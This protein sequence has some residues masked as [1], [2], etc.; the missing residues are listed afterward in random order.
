MVK[1]LALGSLVGGLLAA[2]LTA[3]HYAASFLIGTSFIPFD[4]FNWMVRVLPGDL[5]TF[6]IDMMIDTMLALG[7]SVV[8][9]AKTAERVSAVLQFVTMLLLVGALLFAI[10][11]LRK[12]RRPRL[13]GLIAGAVIG[14]PLLTISQSIAQLGI[15]SL[16]NGLWLLLSF[17]LWGWLM[18]LAYG[19]LFSTEPKA[20]IVVEA[21]P[22]NVQVINRRK[23]LVQLGAS[24]AV[25]TVAGTGIGAALS[26]AERARLA[27]GGA[28]ILSGDG[29]AIRFPNANDPVMPVPGTRPEYTPIADHYQVFLQ[30]EPTIIEEAEWVLPIGGMVSNP[31]MFTLQ[32]FRDEFESFDQ[33]VTLTCISGRVGTGLIG[34][35]KWTGV[36]AQDVL[37][38]VGVQPEAKYLFITSG[39]GFYET[40]DLELIRNDRRIMFCYAWDDKLLPKDH[41]FPLR[42]WIPDLYGMKQ[43]KWITGIE[44]TD[45]DQPGYWVERNWDKVARVKAASTIHTVAV[46]NIGAANGQQVIPIGGAAYAGAR[47]IGS[48]EIRVDGGDW[49]S[50]QLR[51]PLSETTWVIWRYEW[52][53]TEGEHLFEVRCTEADGT[54]QIEEA[55]TARPDGSSGIHSFEAAV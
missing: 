13:A 5:I 15:S 30:T 8:D 28:S 38:A 51:A 10:W 35:T 55:Q 25:I 46:D 49:Q 6:G 19:R 48:V 11:H 50:A 16:L 2:A 39:D 52:P 29:A 33:Y 23:F 34:T 7:L 54:P 3:V 32:Q 36:S 9:L 37:E 40:I 41:G 43:P 27:A 21:P 26:R 22:A 24:T 31:R 12:A 47:G 4:F 53:F 44:V 17:L 20:E 1:K 18:G 45:V 42:I 14:L